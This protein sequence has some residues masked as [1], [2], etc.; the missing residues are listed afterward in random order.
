MM[1]FLF[2]GEGWQMRE[3]NVNIPYSMSVNWSNWRLRYFSF[4][5]IAMKCRIVLIFRWI[6]NHF[7]RPK[8]NETTSITNVYSFSSEIVLQKKCCTTSSEFYFGPSS[9]FSLCRCHLCWLLFRLWM[10]NLEIWPLFT[11]RSLSVLVSCA[12]VIVLNV[13]EKKCNLYGYN[14][15]N[16][17][18]V[19]ISKEISYCFLGIFYAMHFFFVCAAI[20]IVRLAICVC[21]S[22][23]HLNRI[24]GAGQT[25][26]SIQSVWRF[27]VN[28]ILVKQKWFD[29]SNNFWSNVLRELLNEPTRI[30]IVVFLFL[31]LFTELRINDMPLHIIHRLNYIWFFIFSLALS[32]FLSFFHF[33]FSL[34]LSHSNRLRNGT[35]CSASRCKNRRRLWQGCAQPFIGI[36]QFV[37]PKILHFHI[38]I[39]YSIVFMID[40][41]N[42]HK[43]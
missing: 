43:S 16:M 32:L 39:E 17:K 24:Y 31:F 33:I 30:E 18:L 25:I 35:V 27:D 40:L 29:V 21:L 34:S 15:F 3:W 26:C 9:W 23:C 14:G 6:S 7:Q 38:R 2:L 8:V 11:L 28:H 42:F 19:S 12:R 20:E 13:R 5:R 10:D 37:D 1:V 41:T 22:W 36:S 4:C